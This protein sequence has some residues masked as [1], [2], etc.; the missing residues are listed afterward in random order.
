VHRRYVETDAG[1]LHLQ[2]AGSGPD[3]VLLHW[4]P[5]SARMYEHELPRLAELGFRAI[6]VDLPGFGRSMKPSLPKPFDWHAN[7]VAQGLA[8]A[9]IDRYAVLG[10]HFS[11]PIAVE[12]TLREDGGV[13]ALLL[14]GAPQLL[15]P[16]AAAEIGKK[17]AKTTGPGLHEDGSHRTFL[18][19]QAINAY[20]IFDPDFTLNE[21]T[22]PL[23]Y[24]MIEDYLATGMPEDFGAF[25]PYD[26]V[27][28]LA[29]V[30]VPSC[31]LTAETDPLR[32]AQAPTAAAL[33]A[34][35][36]GVRAVTLAGG[37]PLHDPARCGQYADAIA[38][39]LNDALN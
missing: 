14:D 19:D 39:F 28:K 30:E 7:V 5:L 9:G 15:P 11:A 36:G 26:M 23:I 3:V 18:W 25:A 27:E 13:T 17:V 34:G 4:T 10:A 20:E 21:Q 32:S 33:K 24:R 37:H 12:L 35:T 16:E 6:G 29:E 8:G 38:E 31:V 1:Q 22:L 2:M